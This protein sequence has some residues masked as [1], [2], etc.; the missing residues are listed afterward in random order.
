MYM[1]VTFFGCSKKEETER[2][3]TKKLYQLFAVQIVLMNSDI[4]FQINFPENL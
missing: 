3:T 1:G 2:E 4:L